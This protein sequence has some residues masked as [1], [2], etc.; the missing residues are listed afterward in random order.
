MKRGHV[1]AVIFLCAIGA[2][3]GNRAFGWDE[4]GHVLITRLAVEG[5][6]STMPAWLRTP[7]VRARLDYLSTEADRWRGQG[8]VHLDHIN[9][10]DH[11]FD[12]EKIYPFGLSLKT[13][14]P[15]RREFTD[16]LAKQRALNP[17]KFEAVGG[18]LRAPLRSG[19]I[20]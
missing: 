19:A 14:P 8:N 13:L 1:R 2:V 9:K 6:P 4:E 18:H 16:L 7:K 15:L 10:P 11:F 12:V 20:S 5:L 17:G 3:F